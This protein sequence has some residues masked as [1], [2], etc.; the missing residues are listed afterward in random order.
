[1]FKS[2]INYK[3]I[4]SLDGVPLN[5]S[6]LADRPNFQLDSDKIDFKWNK[7]IQ[8]INIENNLKDDYYD[9]YLMT[10]SYSEK[11]QLL[12]QDQLNK[13]INTYQEFEGRVPSSLVDIGCGDGSFLK[14]AKDKISMTVG[15][16]PSVRFSTL[17]IQQGY[18]VINDYVS[19]SAKVTEN[20]F[21][22]FISRQV[23]EHLSD[24]LD[25]LLG[26]KAM[27]NQNAIGLI[28][29]PNGYR[30]MLKKRFYDFFPDH[31]NYYSVNSLVALATAAGFNVINCLESF[32]GDYLELWLRND[33]EKFVEKRINDINVE[34]KLVCHNL[35]HR[36]KSLFDLKKKIMIF[37][38]G[39]KTL[40]IFS[41]FSENV[42][43][44]ISGVIDSDPNKIGRYIP[45]TSIE[46]LSLS[47][48]VTKKPDVIFILA[49]SYVK[50]IRDVIKKK[51]PDVI[52]LTLDNN[53]IIEL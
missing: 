6:Y 40:S 14:H 37:G 9:N 27:L 23:F 17:A 29:V 20:F 48:C 12:Q 45:N 42:S 39:A 44:Y 33:D 15:I 16:E 26:I 32:G 5:V 2:K 13:L 46:V 11:N 18:D 43:R 25:V 10:S 52:I 3:L 49:L 8:H 47:Q 22:T 1:M 51:L 34:R 36:I 24:P 41:G 7:K 21:D 28:E 30:S 19:S 4:G 50:E 38:C 53:K 35:L 31:L